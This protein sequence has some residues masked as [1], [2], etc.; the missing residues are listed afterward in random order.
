MDG[1]H[2]DKR[3]ESLK[4][5]DRQQVPCDG[6]THSSPPAEATPSASPAQTAPSASP[7]E[8]MY[9]EIDYDSYP[10]PGAGK[11]VLKSQKIAPHEPS[12]KDEIRERFQQMREISR[13]YR[14]ASMYSSRFMDRRV[15]QDHAFVFYKQGLFMQDFTDDYS[16][17]TPFSQYFPCYQLM[18]DEQLRTYFTWRSAVRNGH[19]ADT[20]LSIAFLYLYELLGNIGVSSPQDGL[21]KLMFFWKAFQVHNKT[22]DKYVIR[23]L[24]DY[25]IYYELPHSFKKFVTE[26]HLAMH[27]PKVANNGDNFSLF[28]AISK[29]DIRKSAFFTDDKAEMITDCFH[30][31]LNTLKQVFID[32][33][34]HFD[35]SIFEPAKGMTAWTPFQDALFSP[36][37]QQRDRRIVLSENEIYLC[38][39]NKWTF[40]TVITNESGKAFIGYVMKQMESVLRKA[41]QY[42]HKLSANINMVTHAVI[43]KLNEKGLS[44]EKIVTDAVLAFYREATKT[45]VKVNHQALSSIRREALATQEKL[46]VPDQDVQIALFQA[47]HTLSFAM[48]QKIPPSHDHSSTT[49]QK[50]PPIPT[51]QQEQKQEP[52]SANTMWANFGNTLSETELQALSV[53]IRGNTDIKK[54]ADERGIMLEVLVDG[55][56]EKAMDSIGDNLMDDAFNVYDDYV[57]DVKE[58]LR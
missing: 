8:S 38:S 26:N 36:W 4:I 21:E 23:W 9:Y 45:V 25:H 16:G 5:P 20:S 56:N 11:F 52:A 42:K 51:M 19:V 55:I 33:G 32:N 31:V 37:I 18:N 12:E 54:F 47:P 6:A 58:L 15:Q 2:T 7:S 24:K 27:Y 13:K 14:P 30:D 22:I 49:L 46:T 28:C 17:N 40:S 57:E 10:I 34:I 43:G 41:T 3:Y 39:Q 29:Y 53:L 35:N 48:T 1:Y 44:L 50:M